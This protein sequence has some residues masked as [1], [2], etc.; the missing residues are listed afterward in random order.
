MRHAPAAVNGVQTFLDTPAGIHMS[1]GQQPEREARTFARLPS[2]VAIR[3]WRD[4]DFPAIQ[5]L[6]S[7]EGWTTPG[8]R[9]D[10]ALAAWRASW[11]ALVAVE[12]DDIV[13]FCRAVSDGA[14]TT[15]IA[16]ILV[17]PARRGH[18]IARAMLEVTQRLQPG[19]RLDLL[20][21]GDADPFYQRLRF[22]P[23]Q[24]FRRSWGELEET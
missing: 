2:G 6:S 11:P 3:A 24:G 12:G 23:F 9:P 8:E 18:G 16:E 22:R 5:R 4:G 20:S 15:Y 10:S 14:V 21:T 13:G 17:I 19:T 1:E 7:A